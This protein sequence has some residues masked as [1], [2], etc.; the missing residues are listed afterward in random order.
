MMPRR[1]CNSGRVS[2]RWSLQ[3]A[4]EGRKE[5][6]EEEESQRREG[7]CVEEEDDEGKEAGGGERGLICI[8]GTRHIQFS[9]K[10]AVRN[11]AIGSKSN[12]GY[13]CRQVSFR[14]RITTLSIGSERGQRPLL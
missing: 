6:E 8:V 4:R 1:A 14:S 13:R 11:T 2:K 9:W 5:E 10:M 3:R 12:K 7:R